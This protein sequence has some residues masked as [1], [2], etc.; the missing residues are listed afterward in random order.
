MGY[1]PRTFAEGGKSLRHIVVV[2]CLIAALAGCRQPPPEYVSHYTA[3]PS[4]SPASVAAEA[5]VAIIGGAYTAGTEWGGNGPDGWPAL[6]AAQLRQQGTAIVPFVGA[7]DGSGYVT[8]GDYQ[9]KVFADQIPAVVRPNDRLVIVFGSLSDTDVPAEELQPAVRQTLDSASAAAPQAKI[10]VI[11]PA[12]TDPNP[13]DNVLQARDV[14][15]TEAGL[16][17]AIFVDPIAEGW[18]INRPDLIG[19]DGMHPTNAGHTVMAE[20]IALLIGQQ[21]QSP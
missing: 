21:L 3:P 9:G 17:G 4:S 14:I 7:E 10:V 13:P 15:R 6:I 8:P 16:T 20:K 5:A 12:W 19:S 1:T 11:G 2:L 18:F